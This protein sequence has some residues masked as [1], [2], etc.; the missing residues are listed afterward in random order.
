MSYPY[1]ETFVNL[2][3]ICNHCANIKT[4]L[5]RVRVLFK[6]VRQILVYVTLNLY[7]KVIPRLLST[8]HV[9]GTHCAIYEHPRSKI[10]G[11]IRVTS[12]TD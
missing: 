1:F 2:H 11:G 7:L 8:L 10:K 4:L 3:T 9:I 12:K 5:T 6:A